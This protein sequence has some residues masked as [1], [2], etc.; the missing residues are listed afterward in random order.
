MDHA[1]IR[2]LLLSAGWREK[3]VLQALSAQSLSM[4]VPLPPDRGGAREAFLHLTAFASLYMAVIS[5]IILFFT[6][7]NLLFPDP[8][9]ERF[10]DPSQYFGTIH[11]SLA[12][13]IITFPLFLWISRLLLREIRH[14]PE[15]ASSLVRRWLTYLTLFVAALAVIGDLITLLFNLLQGEVSIRFLLKVFVVLLL[16]GLTF[17]YYFL[18]LHAAADK[19]A[20]RARRFHSAFAATATGVVAVALAWGFAVTGSPIV[21]RQRQFDERKVEDLRAISNEIQNIVYEGEPWTPERTPKHPVPATLEEARQQAR[22][23]QISI[24]DP[25][26][27]APYEYRVTDDTHYQLCADFRTVR[28]RPYDIFWNHAAEPA[29]YSFD[30]ANPEGTSSTKG[31]IVPAQ[32]VPPSPQPTP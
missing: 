24:R 23:Q 3:D 6:Y 13:V 20:T 32:P 12:S 14:T 27:G 1:T 28:D 11:W 30:V 4:P 26:T 19:P 7:L 16:A 2:L 9:L 10:T 21:A 5:L 25:Q 17:S 31:A 18:S 22:Y 29:C 8:A 15:R